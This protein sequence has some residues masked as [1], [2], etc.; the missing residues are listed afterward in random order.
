MID[1]PEGPAHRPAVSCRVRV[2]VQPQESTMHA[3]N[4]RV[5]VPIAPALVAVTIL[6]LTASVVPAATAFEERLALTPG[7]SF[8]IDSDVGSIT[9]TGGSDDGAIVRV[10][11]ERDDV[12]ERLEWSF[13]SDGSSAVVRVEKPRSERGL[14]GWFGRSER[15][16]LKID[17]QVPTDTTVAIDTAGGA[18]EVR[19]L[20]GRVTADTSGGAITVAGI[21][22]DVDADTSG[23]GIRVAD[24]R[25]NAVLDTSGGGIEA[26]NVDGQVEADTS[27]GGIHLVDVTGDLSADTSGG[28]IEIVNAGGRVLADT[29]GGGIEVSFAAGN[30]R[31]GRLET[32][33]GGITVAIDPGVALEVDASTSGG[34]VRTDLPLTVR[35]SASKRALRGT[36]NGGGATLE[37]RSTGGGIRIE[38]I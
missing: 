25:G 19:D 6:L 36:L 32:S 16:D 18:I 7:G 17:V 33:G 12:R 35:G 15:Y 11:S 10:R 21:D 14:F 37:L 2:R 9:V 30:D 31:G 29:T 13:E 22:G 23:G 4:D 3:A 26:S 5:T 27:G 24:I 8:R 20:R 34:T 38:P 28:P 1:G